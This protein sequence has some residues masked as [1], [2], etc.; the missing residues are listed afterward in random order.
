MSTASIKQAFAVWADNPMTKALRRIFAAQRSSFLFG[1]AVF[2]Q[3]SLATGAGA[4]GQAT[5]TVT[6]AALGDVVVGISAS[7]DLQGLQVTGYVSAANTV[8]LRFRNDT[9]GAVDLASATY[10]VIVAKAANFTSK[11]LMGMEAS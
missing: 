5:V 10:R 6:G 3:A 4:A 9:G 1:S 7:V 8:V 11:Y 2:D